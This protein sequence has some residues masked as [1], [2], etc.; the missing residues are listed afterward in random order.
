MHS[1]FSLMMLYAPLVAN[2]LFS[3]CQHARGRTNITGQLITQFFMFHVTYSHLGRNVHRRTGLVPLFKEDNP[4]VREDFCY[5]YMTSEFEY[6]ELQTEVVFRTC[7]SPPCLWKTCET[8]VKRGYTYKMLLI[9]S[10]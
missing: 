3:H 10:P 7:Y 8:K 6:S 1:C 4:N 9:L 5:H 2:F